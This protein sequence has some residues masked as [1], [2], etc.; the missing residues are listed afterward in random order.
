[1]RTGPS[2]QALRLQRPISLETALGSDVVEV[3]QMIVNADVIEHAAQATQG[4]THAVG[5][6]EAAELTAP[7]EVWLQVENDARDAS[8]RQFLL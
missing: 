2:V 7:F 4:D 8:L 1:M 3:P 6:A 5:P